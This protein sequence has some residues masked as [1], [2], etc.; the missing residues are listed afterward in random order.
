MPKA[1]QLVAQLVFDYPFITGRVINT[2]RHSS[3]GAGGREK[4]R[5]FF[6]QIR[7]HLRQNCNTLNKRQLQMGISE[8]VR[9][10]RAE[11]RG[12][13]PLVVRGTAVETKEQVRDDGWKDGVLTPV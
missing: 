8:A 12:H 6:R 9:P 7:E 5:T 13:T 1:T 10:E 11:M 2:S 3:K 4:G